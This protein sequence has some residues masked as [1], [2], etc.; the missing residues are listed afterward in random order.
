MSGNAWIIWYS[1]ILESIWRSVKEDLGE[2]W[3]DSGDSL[4]PWQAMI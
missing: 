2:K 1:D 3:K 4:D